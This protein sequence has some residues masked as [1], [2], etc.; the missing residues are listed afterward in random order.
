MKNLQRIYQIKSSPEEVFNA[1]TNSLTLELWTGY[2][3][4]FQLEA[5]TEFSIWDGDIIGMNLEIVP[6]KKI[7]QEWYFEDNQEPSI[8]TIELT[9]QNDKTQVDLSHTN[10]PDDAFSNIEEGWNKYYFGTMRKYLESK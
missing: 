2:P 1:M 5:N 7:V 9:I 6:D 4:V 3:A 8:V 10:I